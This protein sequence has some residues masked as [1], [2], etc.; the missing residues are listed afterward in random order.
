MDKIIITGWSSIL[1]CKV[2]GSEQLSRTYQDWNIGSST[3]SRCP[4]CDRVTN[5]HVVAHMAETMSYEEYLS[6]LDAELG[7]SQ[8]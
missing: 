3:I 1:K 5:H 4:T 2:C 6:S 7:I 8:E